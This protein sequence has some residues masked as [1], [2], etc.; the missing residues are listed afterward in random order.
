MAILGGEEIKL[1][2]ELGNIIITDFDPNRINPNSYNLTLNEK[3]LVYTEEVLD[4]RKDNPTREI[5]I[6]EEGYI[7]Q[8]GTLYLARVNEFTETYGFVPI[9]EGRS[10]VG[11]LALSVHPS[12]GFGDNGFRGYFTLELTVTHPLRVYANE[13]IC[14]I[15]FHTIEGKSIPY[16]GR[17]QDSEDVIACRLYKDYEK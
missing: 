2:R 14:Q 8:P 16:N 10:S 3:L 9:V 1:Q 4:M 17:Y 6:P 11:R 7:L 13:E 5:I 15:V 12:T